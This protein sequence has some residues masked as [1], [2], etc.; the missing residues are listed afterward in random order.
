MTVDVSERA[1]EEAI[2]CA[3][4]AYGP[5]ASPGD[6]TQVRETPPPWDGEPV[7]GGYRRRRPQD[8]DRGLCLLPGDVLDFLLATQPK[9]WQKLRQ[10]HGTEVKERLLARLSR[11]IGRRGA[12]DVLRN[13]V[14]G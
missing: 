13:G 14:K 4:L 1:F 6:A 9:E 2:E 3:L 10:H 8:Y 12:L 11:E 5:D 7:P